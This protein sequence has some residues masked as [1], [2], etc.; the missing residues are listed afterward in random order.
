[1][2]ETAGDVQRHGEVLHFQPFDN[3]DLRVDPLVL[4]VDPNSHFHLQPCLF[5]RKYILVLLRKLIDQFVSAGVLVSGLL[6]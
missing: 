4:S 2:Y 6:L 5:V 3:E 1:V